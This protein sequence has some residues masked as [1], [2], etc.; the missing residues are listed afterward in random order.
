MTIGQGGGMMRIIGSKN[1]GK[2]E[3]KRERAV[4]IDIENGIDNG[5]EDGIEDGCQGSS[6]NCVSNVLQRIFLSAKNR[7]HTYQRTRGFMP[8]LIAI[9]PGRSMT[10]STLSITLP[11]L[12]RTMPFAAFKSR[13]TSR[14]VL[15]VPQRCRSAII[16]LTVSA[17]SPLRLIC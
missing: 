3:Q 14:A 6:L 9:S 15:A 16:S 11:S 2:I 7:Y 5:I 13:S 4:G 10:R 8:D 1:R 12:V 17:S